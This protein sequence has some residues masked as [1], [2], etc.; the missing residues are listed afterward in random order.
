MKINNST[1]NVGSY[2]ARESITTFIRINLLS[3]CT[4]TASTKSR[5]SGVIEVVPVPAP[6]AET[7]G[8]ENE[9]QIKKKKYVQKYKPEWEKSREWLKCYEMKAFC[10]LCNCS[11]ANDVTLLERHSKLAKHQNAVKVKET[12]HLKQLSVTESLS[13]KTASTEKLSK[14]ITMVMHCV[15]HS[16]ALKT[17]STLPQL[18]NFMYPSDKHIQCCSTK[19]AAMVKSIL[20]PYAREKIAKELRSTRFSLIMDEGT[21]ISMT[22]CLVLIVRYLPPDKNT[23]E[24]CFFGLLEIEDATAQGLYNVTVS[25]LNSMNIP[26]VNMIGLATDNAAVMRGRYNSVRKKNFKMQIK[27]YFIKG[28][29]ATH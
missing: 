19:S 24:D 21:D 23:V 27:A 14:E 22:K 2:V 15:Q 18:F 8:D 1:K 7:H 10:K 25:Y 17:M 12:N 5:A 20:G 4:A 6:V 29:R 16:L 28:A 26:L 9:P 3:R 11:L 13:Q